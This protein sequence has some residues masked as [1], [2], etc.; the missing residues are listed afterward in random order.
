MKFKL[1]G[2]DYFPENFPPTFKSSGIADF[3]QTN[4]EVGYSYND[5]NSYHASLYNAS[6]L[7]GNRRDFSIIHP[8]VAYRMADFIDRHCMKLNEYF[9]NKNHSYTTPFLSTDPQKSI[10]IAGLKKY[11]DAKFNRFSRFEYIVYTDISRFF[12]SLY[13]H[14]IPWAYHTKPVAKSRR[15]PKDQQIFFNEADNIIQSSQGGQTIGLP[16]G[17]KMSLIFSELIG[18]AIDNEFTKLMSS[19]SEKGTQIIY[20]FI[21]Y[22]DDILIGTNSISE[23]EIALATYRKA[24]RNFELDLN[25]AKTNIYSNNYTFEKHWKLD[26]SQKFE[27]VRSSDSDSRI[28]NLRS[29]LDFGY[30]LSIENKNQKILEYVIYMVIKSKF[31]YD[32]DLWK[33]IES[34]LMRVI[35]ISGYTIDYVVKLILWRYKLYK[36][37]N[38][39]L[40]RE[41]I[42]LILSK[43]IKLGHDNEVCWIICA[44]QV[45]QINIPLKIARQIVKNCGPISIVAIINC[46]KRRLVVE[47]IF[48]DIHAQIS[49]ELDIGRNWPVFLEL[50]KVDNLP[51]NNKFRKCNIMKQMYSNK[52]SIYE[53]ENILSLLKYFGKKNYEKNEEILLRQINSFD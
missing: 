36:D 9:Q 6:Q 37:I 30:S 4:I 52:V 26:I 28:E 46:A 22:N 53:I 23:T 25:Q 16:V 34:F 51:A 45:L 38:I 8:V 44:C 10:E 3:F 29:T 19:I 49:G 18:H 5:E 43:S 50:A 24:V 7:N 1:I 20:D 12:Y 27:F 47:S 13:T 2:T 17:P 11:E 48:K 40:W 39:K 33:I 21:R 42:Y 35:L 41:Q 32:D 15:S 31:I 14:V